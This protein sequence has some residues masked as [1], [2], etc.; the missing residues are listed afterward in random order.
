MKENNLYNDLLDKLK[1]IEP[2]LSNSEIL[3][4]DIIQKIAKTIPLSQKSR[5]MRIS[6]MIS[7][8][9]ASALI[10]LFIYDTMK[11]STSYYSKPAIQSICNNSLP[12]KIFQIEKNQNMTIEE[13]ISN[14]KIKSE[15]KE[16]LYN[17]FLARNILK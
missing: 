8:I 16:Q 5:I 1:K 7:G 17:S 10:C 3:T 13:F 9:A 15:L 14:K 6:G 12:D 2:V 11:F 4:D